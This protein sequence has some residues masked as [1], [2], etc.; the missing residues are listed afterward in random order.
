MATMKIGTTSQAYASADFTFQYNP[1]Q[2]NI[3]L[4]NN[5]SIFEIPYSRTHIFLGAGGV[6]VRQIVLNGYV[7]GASKVTNYNN[8]AAQLNENSVKRFWKNDSYYYLV[9]GD[10]VSQ[11]EQGGRTNFIDYVASLYCVLPYL[12]SGTDSTYTVALTNNSKTTLNDATSGST[13]AFTNAGNAPAF[14][15]WQIANAGGASTITKIEIGDTS[16]YDTSPH[17]I[18]WTGTLAAGSTLLISV[19][20]YVSQG[21]RGTF[22]EMRFGYPTISGVWTGSMPQILG[23]ALPWVNTGT[24]DQAFSIRINGATSYTGT[25]TVTATY[26]ASYL[27]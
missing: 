9:L 22:K 8:L 3:P 14:V 4:K 25:A 15:Q 24:T 27:G 1:Q 16:D 2:F 20:N 23:D 6:G 21:A 11:T 18:T 5:L 10:S 26:Q 19:F 13:G 7:S 12:L 17:K